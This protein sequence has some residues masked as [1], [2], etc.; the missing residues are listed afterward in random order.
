MSIGGVAQF[1]E[2]EQQITKE[3]RQMLEQILDTVSILKERDEQEKS[4]LIGYYTIQEV[5]DI[6]LKS[7]TT[8]YREIK[9]DTFPKQVKLGQKSSGWC[10]KEIHA[11]LTINTNKGCSYISEKGWSN[12]YTDRYGLKN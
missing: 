10:K 2:Q 8:I 4:N 5:A 7:V 3:N 1:F 11:W 6:S 12:I 9:K